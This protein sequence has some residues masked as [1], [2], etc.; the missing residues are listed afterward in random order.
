MQWGTT[1][2]LCVSVAGT[3]LRGEIL[4]QG[5]WD[6]LLTG[7]QVL[8]LLL[9]SLTT[10]YWINIHYLVFTYIVKC[11]SSRENLTECYV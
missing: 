3:I 9:C 2:I 10:A 1:V 11:E 7:F 6:N 8:D 5:H 4:C